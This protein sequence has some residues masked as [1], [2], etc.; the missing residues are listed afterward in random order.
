MSDPAAARSLPPP[1]DVFLAAVD[2]QLS[3]PI[4]L[5]CS[6]GFVITFCYG[7]PRPT[8]DVDYVSIIPYDEQAR[9]QAIAGPDSKLAKKY[10]VYLQYV[11]W[12]SLPEDYVQRLVEMFPGRFERL[13]LLALDPYDLALS[14]LDRNSPKDREDVAFLARTVPLDPAVLRERY[15]SELRPYLAREKWHDQTL[16]LWLE[17]CFR[18]V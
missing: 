3:Q 11:G 18:K 14:K 9:L 17:S 12:A 4:E 6:G 15:E 8:G 10:K 16:E 1:W 13:R 2:R 7:L 5:H